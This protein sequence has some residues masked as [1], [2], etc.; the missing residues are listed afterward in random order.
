M[1]AKNDFLR[2]ALVAAAS[3]LLYAILPGTAVRAQTAPQAAPPIPIRTV[4][5]ILSLPYEAALRGGQAR[6]RGVIT[7]ASPA[8]LVV[9]D[10]TSGIWIDFG[11]NGRLQYGPGDVMDV[12]GQIATG[13]YTP[14]LYASRVEKIGH[15]TL[16]RPQAASFAQLSSGQFDA[17]YVSVEGTVRTVYIRK[18]K[19]FQDETSLAIDMDQGRVDAVLPHRCFTAAYSLIGARVRLVATVLIRK[20]DNR[21]STGVFLVVTDLNYVK[22]LKQGP[23][24][25]FATPIISMEKLMRYGSGTDYFHP[26]RLQGQL[27]YYEQGQRMILQNGIQAI[28]V[29]I[30]ESQP[31]QIGD[32]I[33]AVGFPAPEASGPILHDAI[34]RCLAH[35]AP[36]TP[37]SVP[38]SDALSSRY[39]FTL[40]SLDMRLLRVINEPNRTLFLLEN[41]NHVVTAELD[42]DQIPPPALVAGSLVRVSGINLLSVEGGLNYIDSVIHSALLI[43][44]MSDIRLLKPASWWTERRLFYLSATLG[45]LALGSIA[46]LLYVQLKRWRLAAV[47]RERERLAHDIHD[48]LA[49]SFAGIGF[50]LQVIRRAAANKD[51]ELERHIDVARE[52]VQFSHREARRGL[53]TRPSEEVSPADLLG[54]LEE[55]AHA[56][57]ASGSIEIAASTSGLPRPIPRAVNVQL[58]RIGQE[59]IANAI[60][61]ADASRIQVLLEYQPEAVL[62]TIADNG[63]GFEMRGNLLGFGVRGMRKRAAQVNA[64]FILESSPGRGTCVKVI[65]PTPPAPRLRDLPTVLRRFFKSASEPVSYDVNKS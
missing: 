12:T 26:V 41:G 4:S 50:Q 36:Q 14:Q 62:L 32:W 61:H 7:L 42:E 3:A 23:R 1:T 57:V 48:T 65:A 6:I 15:S 27:T 38:L 58:F 46:L 53:A 59:A 47:M 29:L 43:R 11:A 45:L 17:Q 20:N 10:N 52:L 5:S 51:S 55:C 34:A 19:S 18:D 35:K 30:P 28:E 9:H 2:L 16:P 64:E 22:V 33:E 39:R 40:I 13:R 21:Q 8:G 63:R 56:L 60:R 24:D 44:S 54:A 31:F 49:Q 37:A 25:P